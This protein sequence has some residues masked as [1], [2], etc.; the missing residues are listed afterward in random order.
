M[1]LMYTVSNDQLPEFPG[2]L[3]TPGLQVPGDCTTFNLSPSVPCYD[4]RFVFKLH[5][6]RLISS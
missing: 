6:A 1:L 3:Q 4:A 5:F 2:D